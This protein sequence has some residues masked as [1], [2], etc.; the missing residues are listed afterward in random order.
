MG[1]NMFEGKQK[2]TCLMAVHRVEMKT[3]SNLVVRRNG[4]TMKNSQPL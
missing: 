1:G 4:V 3:E 2:N